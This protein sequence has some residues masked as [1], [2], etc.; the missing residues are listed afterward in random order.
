[1]NLS[2]SLPAQYEAVE[3]PTYYQVIEPSMRSPRGPAELMLIILNRTFSDA[4]LIALGRC[5]DSSGV[6]R[7]KAKGSA[8]VGSMAAPHKP[9]LSQEKAREVAL[10]V[11]SAA[12]T[13]RS[14]PGLNA[15]FIDAEKPRPALPA[16]ENHDLTTTTMSIPPPTAVLSPSAG[17]SPDRLA[18][19]ILTSKTIVA[20]AAKIC[21]RTAGHHD[22][23]TTTMLIPPPAAVPPPSAGASPDRLAYLILVSKTIVAAAEL[24]PFPYVKGALG[25]MIPILE[26]VQKMA[27]NRED[28][29]ELCDS[30]VTIIT[31]LKEEISRHGADAVSRL[32]QFCD[33]LKS[34]LLEIQQ[35]LGKF[36]K[37]GF[38]NRIKEFGRS[39]SIGDELSRYKG[40]VNELR[41]NF[42][43]VNLLH[44][45]H[46]LL[47]Q[48]QRFT[49]VFF[50]DASTADTL[51]AGL[52]NIA[53]TQSIGN[54]HKDA[55]RWLALYNKEWLLIFDNADDPKLNLFNFFPQSTHGNIL[56]TSRNPQLRVHAPDA[57]HKISDLEEEAA[58]KLLLVSAA[59]SATSENEM[60]ATEIVKVFAM[61]IMDSITN[62]SKVLYCFPLA[63]VQAGAYISKSGA[64]RRYL[65][66]Y[67]HNHTRLFNEVPVQSHDKYALSVYTTWDISFRCLNETAAQFL[68]LCSFLHHE[69]I[70]EGIFS[71]A[72]VYSPDMLGLLG[73]AQDQMKEPQK[74]LGQF[75]TP[76]GMWDTLSFSEMAAELQEYSLI[77]QD[78]NTG[79]FSIHP[80]VHSWSRNTVSSMDSPR[81]CAAA[82]LAMSVNWDDKLFTMRLLPHLNTVLQMD[83]QLA[84]KFLWPYQQIY[85]D[86]GNFQHAQE[87]C[88]DLLKKAKSSLGA[89]HP[90][91]LAIM[92]HLALTYRGLGKFSEAEALQVAILE[93]WKQTSGS[94][95]PDTL[96]AMGN[97]AYTYRDLGKFSE[98]EALQVTV[99]EK[100][101]QTSGSE[102]PDTLTAMN[103]L[104]LTYRDLGKFS[105]AEALQVAVL[106]KRKQT[107]GS[108]HPDTLTAMN[109]LALTYRGLGKFS[110]VEALQVAVLEK[111]KQTSGSEHPDTLTAM[112]NLAYTYRDLGKFSEAE[113][114]QVAVLEKRKQTSGSEHPDTLTAMNNLAITYQGLGKFSEAEALQ[115]AVLEKMKQTSGSEHP[116][117][118]T[119][120]GNLAYTYRDLGK[121]SEAKALQVTVL[122]KRKQTSGSEHPDTLTAMGNLAY[123]Y[124]DLGKFSEAEAL[125]VAVLEKR[126]QASG[127]EHP[128][129]LTAMGNLALAY[130]GL[131]KFS[132][133]EALQVAVLEKRKQTSGSEHPGTLIA[134]GNLAKTYRDLGKFTDAEALQ[135]AVLEKVK[136]ILGSEHPYTLTAMT[137]LGVTYQQALG[138]LAEAEAL[139][140]VVLEKRTQIL[141]SEHPGTLSAMGNLAKTYQKLG[142]L[143]EAKALQVVV[144]EKS[145]QTLG[146]EHPHT[147]NA[148]GNLAGTYRDLGRL[149]EAEALEVVVVEKR[150][151]T[152]GPEHPDT[153]T[154]MTNL[155]KSQ[156]G[157]GKLKEAAQLL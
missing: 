150:R 138:K 24:L 118:L 119:A 66:L 112:G 120:M 130:Q 151:Q 156:C 78:P 95:H 18:N 131:G 42:I 67:E 47:L 90:N 102:H 30:I 137:N 46:L 129:T 146:P 106:E 20:T 89:E 37:K 61:G 108:E 2:S 35:G 4:D 113:A 7:S 70:S 43:H 157:L 84:S 109:N 76:A 14:T 52:K 1:M 26:A 11:G 148:M 64:L 124:Q 149:T 128:D 45:F 10:G 100:R 41:L 104:A 72:A 105:E 65:A 111:M 23:T 5:H 122:E 8:D 99:L 94:E 154:A 59:E 98:A 73:P 28:F 27:K 121:F 53:L 22:L 127:S 60:L 126:K 6:G 21:C 125:Q 101:K 55:L 80:L 25:P 32:T 56:I 145:Q 107:S 40:R 103:N 123:I 117:T 16:A 3:P 83:S 63:V 152:L 140:V 34:L 86:S 110:E 85:Y 75:S 54:D 139:Q 91:T 12:Q 115:V 38:R 74:F 96:T 9:Q 155:A 93:K 135:V 19:L 57:H 97:L 62:L 134:M 13:T 69:G 92:G 88:A 15:V 51:R 33:Q 17:V 144:L 132:E 68:Q 58:V 48:Q 50:L 133:A 39:T 87:L 79:L 142:R 44:N 29:T 153:L 136:Q 114:L 77:N 143:T 116:D 31:M 141:G 147:L 82:L 71:N 81:E 36:Q 49:D